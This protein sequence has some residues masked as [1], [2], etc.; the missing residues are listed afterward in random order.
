MGQDTK[1][2]LTGMLVALAVMI[3]YNYLLRALYPNWDPNR[4]PAPPAQV[5]SSQPAT[6]QAT[7]Q[8]TQAATT[9]AVATTRGSSGVTAAPGAWRARGDE[10]VGVPVSIGSTAPNDKQYAME[11]N[12]TRR[13]ASIDSVTLNS[14]RKSAEDK[15]ARYVFQEPD[16][17][18]GNLRDDTHSLETRSVTLDGKEVDLTSV[19]WKL[20]SSDSTGATFSVDILNG[21][22]PVVR[23]IKTFKLSPRTEDP[24]TPLGYQVDVNNRFVNLTDKPVTVKANFNG[25]TV[26]PRE[27]ERQ[28]DQSFIF[29]YAD[30]NYLKVF[31]HLIESEFTKDHTWKEFT[32]SDKGWPM[33]WM[34]TQSAYFNAIVRPVATDGKALTANWIAKVWG[35]LLNPAAETADDRRVLMRMETSDLVVPAKE[36][37][38]FD[39][40]VYFGPKARGVLNTPYYSSLPRHYDETL[41][42]SG[43]YCGICTWSWLVNVLVWMLAAF[44]FVIRDW[45][46]AIIGLVLVVRAILHPITKKSQVHMVKMQKMGPEMERLK[47]KYADDKDALAKAQMQFYKEQGFTPILGC[48]PMFLQMPIWIALWNALQS[49][50]ELRHAPFLYGFTWIKDLSKPDYLVH[51]QNPVPLPFGWHLAGVNL[52]PLL[53]AVVMYFQ[54]KMQPKPTTMTPEQAQQ[55]KMMTWMS[56]LLF[57]LMLYTGPSGL[58]LYIMTSTAFGIIEGKVIRKHIKEREELEKLGP[59]IVDDLPPAKGG[60]KEPE[61]QKG[62]LERLQ[63]RAEEIRRHADRKK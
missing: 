11:L 32:R 46:L 13:G 36:T 31:S 17:V 22:R 16:R 55:Q 24:N 19:N 27:L 57:P 1:R 33:A 47:K 59:Q 23:L 58:N 29:S 8:A 53:M 56:T 62:W 9:T 48:L 38:Q 18:D 2:L 15:S 10:S 21:D 6:T 45:G 20:D 3:G 5:A 54:T 25:P 12:V 4:K 7:S 41:V 60:G 51:F 40:E 39:M 49:T 30:D 34:G 43:G 14:F 63:E 50:F 61:R 26:P 44:H 28:A 35:E 52:L 37:K 42:I